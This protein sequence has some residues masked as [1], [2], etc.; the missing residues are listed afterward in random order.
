[1]MVQNSNIILLEEVP[2]RWELCTA[3]LSCWKIQPLVYRQAPAGKSVPCSIAS[4]NG[5]LCG[6]GG[7]KGFISIVLFAILLQMLSYGYW[8]VVILIWVKDQSVSSQTVHQT[9]EHLELFCPITPWNCLTA[10]ILSDNHCERTCLF[11][12]QSCHVQSQKAFMLLPSEGHGS[13]NE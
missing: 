13:V 8:A 4:P 6:M 3:E 1:M 5:Q 10:S 7:G 12:H 2:V 9:L 11:S